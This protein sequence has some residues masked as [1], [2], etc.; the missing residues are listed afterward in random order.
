MTKRKHGTPAYMQRRTKRGSRGR[1][2]R[3]IKESLEHRVDDL[4]DRVSRLEPTLVPDLGDILRS[5]PGGLS[6]LAERSGYHRE[7]LYQFA[8]ATRTMKF[9]AKRALA[10][11]KAFGRRRACG[12]QVTV[13]LL[14]QAWFIVATEAGE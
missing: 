5:F 13:D 3:L 7:S 11:V 12:H 1:Q 4:E 14:R 9:P 2:T 6:A 8:T 10:V